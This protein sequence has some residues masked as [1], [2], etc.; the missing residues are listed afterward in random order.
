MN[1]AYIYLVLL[2]IPLII[3]I[4]LI[5]LA[6]RLENTV[7]EKDISG[8]EIAKDILKNKDTY[9]V[10]KRDSVN[11]IYDDSRD[12]L[13][14]STIVFHEPN[15]ISSVVAAFY[16]TSVMEKNICKSNLLRVLDISNLLS[17]LFFLI[18][19]STY[20]LDF[21]YVATAIIIISLT[22]GIINLNNSSRIANN[23]IN[24]LEEKKIINEKYTYLKDIIKYV[25]IARIITVVIDI[26]F[27]GIRKIKS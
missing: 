18:G 11:N 12:T 24:Y 16:A 1:I 27:K 10:E 13:K 14:F 5:L 25:F 20:S 6:K 22:I 26:I 17:I 19:V 4:R 23:A 2:V 15:I 7:N 9:I 21:I 8:F 3:A